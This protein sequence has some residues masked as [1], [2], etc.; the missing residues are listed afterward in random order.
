LIGWMSCLDAAHRIYYTNA[1]VAVAHLFVNAQHTQAFQ[2]RPGVVQKHRPER[3][4]VP[5]CGLAVL[6]KPQHSCV[7][8]MTNDSRPMPWT[9]TFD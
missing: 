2:K 6:Q 8:K 7:A 4:G 3:Y 9:R 5:K 1:H